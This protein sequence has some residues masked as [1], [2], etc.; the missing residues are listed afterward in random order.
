[1]SGFTGIGIDKDTVTTTQQAPL[2]FKLTVGDGN[3]GNQIYTYVKAAATVGQGV[4]VMR[5]SVAGDSGYGA[6]VLGLSTESEMRYVGCAQQA[7]GIP[8]GSY[9]FVLTKGVGLVKVDSASAAGDELVMHSADGELDDAAA[10]DV[11]GP[12]G[13]VLG[14]AIAP[15]TPGL[16]YVSFAG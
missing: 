13:V 15:A 3:D 10:T 5:G 11:N 2:G 12:V 7:A 16:A 4:A 6:C 14:T 1:M 9:G 8:S